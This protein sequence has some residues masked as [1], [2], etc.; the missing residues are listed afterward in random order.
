MLTNYHHTKTGAF[1]RVF[2]GFNKETGQMMAVKEISF[3]REDSK[4][5]R[6]LANEVHVLRRVQSIDERGR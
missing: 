4:F 6:E 2:K 3:S 5:I 1:G